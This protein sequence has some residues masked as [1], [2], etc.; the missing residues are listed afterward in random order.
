[1]TWYAV[2][3]GSGNLLSTGTEKP[4]GLVPG[5]STLQLPAAFD[6]DA[7]GA[8]AIRWNRVTRVFDAYVPPDNVTP[9]V[10]VLLAK[11]MKL[12]AL[13][14]LTAAQQTAIKLVLRNHFLGQ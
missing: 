9:W 13:A 14:N 11:L 4:V 1:M 10:I 5:L 8:G 6:P 12:P 2:V 7:E 3:D